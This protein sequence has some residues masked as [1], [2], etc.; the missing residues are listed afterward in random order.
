[1]SRVAGYRRCG[2]HRAKFVAQSVWKLKEAY[3]S[4]GCGMI[5]RV[6]LFRDVVEHLLDG[7]P[8]DTQ[9][10]AVWMTEDIGVEEERDEKAVRK[11]CK[12]RGVEFQLWKD[13]KYY[14]DE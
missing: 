5:M 4:L 11:V 8:S 1:R 2:P 6:G 7:L 9:V 13:E 14:I 10:G 12:E 3:E